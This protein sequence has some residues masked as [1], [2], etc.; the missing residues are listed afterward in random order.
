MIEK[1]FNHLTFYTRCWIA[2]WTWPIFRSL[3]VSTTVGTICLSQEEQ[4]LCINRA[5]VPELC[6]LLKILATVKVA[7]LVTVILSGAK[8][9]L[10]R[11]TGEKNPSGG[12]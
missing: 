2:M 10:L 7:V 9:L 6:K 1:L 4:S 8:D 5:T 12:A 11:S 3:G